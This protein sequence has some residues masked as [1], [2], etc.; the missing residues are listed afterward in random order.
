MMIALFLLLL[1]P[2]VHCV[3]D[4][5]SMSTFSQKCEYSFQNNTIH[6]DTMK[7][8]FKQVYEDVSCGYRSINSVD[9][10]IDEGQQDA[11]EETQVV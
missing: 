2:N 4:D 11:F 5:N 6:A 9:I 10:T 8:V 1:L 3:C 7:L